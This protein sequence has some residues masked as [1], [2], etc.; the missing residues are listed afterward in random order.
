MVDERNEDEA[1]ILSRWEEVEA[2]I[3]GLLKEIRVL[4]EKIG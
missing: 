2:A 1:F 3:D 4:L